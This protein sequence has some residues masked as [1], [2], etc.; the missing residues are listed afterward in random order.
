MIVGSTISGQC[1]ADS[2]DCALTT[3]TDLMGRPFEN[4]GLRLSGPDDKRLRTGIVDN[5]HVKGSNRQPSDFA[6]NAFGSS[7]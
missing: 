3:W 4:F 2:A 5:E 6:S 7:F 1:Q